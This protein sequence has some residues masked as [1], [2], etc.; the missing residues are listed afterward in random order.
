MAKISNDIPPFIV[1]I[2]SAV[3]YSR[4]TDAHYDGWMRSIKE[5]IG[6]HFKLRKRDYVVI[7]IAFPIRQ[8]LCDLINKY[9]FKSLSFVK[10]AMVVPLVTRWANANLPLKRKIN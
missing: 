2:L 4:I 1:N 5:H 8:D 3:D 7:E 10:Q 9:D 6:K